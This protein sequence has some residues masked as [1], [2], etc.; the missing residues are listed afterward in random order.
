MNNF[1]IIRSTDTLKWLH[2]APVFDS[3]NAMFY[4]AGYIP[5]GKEL[6]KIQVTSFC[7]TRGEAVKM[8]K[9]QGNFRSYEIAGR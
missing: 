1:G 9:E 3:G 7:D 2:A 4:Q 5:E 8:G 6:L